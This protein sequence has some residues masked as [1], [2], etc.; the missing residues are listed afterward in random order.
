MQVVHLFTCKLIFL[1]PGSQLVPHTSTIHHIISENQP[2]SPTSTIFHAQHSRSA[3]P[4]STTLPII[5]G[6]HSF[7]TSAILLFPHS[8]SATTSAEETSSLQMP[9]ETK[10]KPTTPTQ[11]PVK[12]LT[13]KENS[14]KVTLADYS[15]KNVRRILAT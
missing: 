11:T 14:L 15:E 3:S 10:P 1:T 5:R 6:S 7:P 4:K 12:T 2:G 13:I 9:L 8:Q